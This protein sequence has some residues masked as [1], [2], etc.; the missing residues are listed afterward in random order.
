VQ[1]SCVFP[2]H[3]RDGKPTPEVDRPARPIMRRDVD[4]SGIA[5]RR[6]WLSL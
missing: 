4:G 2:V 6:G 5:R 1:V 3:V